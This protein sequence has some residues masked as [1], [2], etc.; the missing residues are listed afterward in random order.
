ML[1]RTQECYLEIADDVKR[2]GAIPGEQPDPTPDIERRRTAEEK[3]TDFV[4]NPTLEPKERGAVPP[5]LV[6]PI[7]VIT[8]FSFLLSLLVVGLTTHW[9]CGNA[10]L[11]SVA[12]SLQASLVC[13]AGW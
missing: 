4:V 3:V 9:H 6:S 7:P 8:D 2:G 11:A 1:G 12:I 13:Y 5:A 10:L